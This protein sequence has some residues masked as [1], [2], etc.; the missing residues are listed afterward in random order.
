MPW[1]A[2]L[3][4]KSITCIDQNEITSDEARIHVGSKTFWSGSMSQGQTV[5]LSGL[6]N[7]TIGKNDYVDIRVWEGDDWEPWPMPNIDPDDLL[8]H[9]Q[10][11]SNWVEPGGSD[12]HF[13]LNFGGDGQYVIDAVLI[14]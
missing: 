7:I 8:G 2:E 10:V 11:Y 3:D 14:A 5:D 13:S 9:K 4:L 12:L 1:Y 6:D